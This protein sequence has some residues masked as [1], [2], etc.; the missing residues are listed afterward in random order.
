MQ[1]IMPFLWLDA[2]LNEVVDYYTSIF[3][4]SKVTSSNKTPDGNLMTASIEIEEQPFM[5]LSGGTHFKFNES[6]SFMVRCETQQEVDHYWNS[7]TADGG[8][9]SMCGWLKDKYGLSWQITPTVLLDL[10]SAGGEGGQ[11]VM[12][13]MMQM[14][15]IDIAKIEEAYNW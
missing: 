14:R 8:Q 12:Q 13:A 6:V 15:K 3:K 10:M 1:K 7:L 4:S 2:N 5:L 11:R 9:E